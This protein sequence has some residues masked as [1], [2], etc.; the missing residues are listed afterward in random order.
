MQ[1]GGQWSMIFN[2]ITKYGLMPKKC[3]PETFSSESSGR[4]NS[5]LNSQVSSKNRIF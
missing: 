2:I 5:V 4:M 3:F 1:D